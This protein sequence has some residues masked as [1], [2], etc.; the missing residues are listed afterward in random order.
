MTAGIDYAAVE[1]IIK[2]LFEILEAPVQQAR[3]KDRD[4]RAGKFLKKELDGLRGQS[5]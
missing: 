1:L 2:P 3:L 5:D 4:T